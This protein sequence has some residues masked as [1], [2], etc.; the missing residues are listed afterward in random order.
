MY[1]LFISDVHL[2][3]ETP[4]VAG[5][6]LQLLKE[7]GI[8]AEAVYILGDLFEYW[9]GDDAIT[10]LHQPFIAALKSLNDL[11]IPVF[12]IHGNRDFLIGKDFEA[13]TGCEILD[14]PTVIDLYGT[15]T[16]LTHGDLLCSDDQAYLAFRKTVR[17]PNWQAYFLSM[18]MDDRIALAKKARDVS[19]NHG[20]ANVNHEN[21]IMDAN[22]QTIE[23]FLTEHNVQQMIHGHTHRPATHDFNL[24]NGKNAKRY[25]LGDWERQPSFIIATKDGIDLFDPRVK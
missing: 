6:F 13:L 14:D 15:R 23:A 7:K 1:T 22:Q 3:P 11:N 25:V 17:D 24:P 19:Q 4:E 8:K 21:E 18:N 5:Q 12:F 10:R 16:L 2:S 20:A 9:L